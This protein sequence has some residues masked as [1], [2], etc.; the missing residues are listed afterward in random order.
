M[1]NSD[2]LRLFL[3]VMREGN[4][5]AAARRAGIDHSTVARRISALEAALAARLFDR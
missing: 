2:D 3:A 4:M 1:L 5:L